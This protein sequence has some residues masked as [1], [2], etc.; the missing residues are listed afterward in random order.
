MTIAAT[1][2]YDNTI[3]QNIQAYT[4]SVHS[5]DG[6][7]YDGASANSSITFDNFQNASFIYQAPIGITANT[8]IVVTIAPD[9]TENLL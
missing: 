2:R 1:D 9:Q 8:G 3:G 6:K 4:I 5:G 7:I